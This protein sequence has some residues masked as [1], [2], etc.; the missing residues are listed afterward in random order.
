MQTLLVVGG[1]GFIGRSIC[2]IA[3]REGHDVRSVSRS[4]RPELDAP[5]VDGVSWTSA[6]L[7]RPNAWRDRLDGVDAVVH[8][9]G[10][11]SESATA[12]VT[13]ER[14]NGDAAILTALEAER[15]GVDTFVF[16]SSA[17]KPPGVRNAYI[18]AKRRAETAIADLDVENVT[19]RPGPVYGPEQPHVPAV[20]NT[21]FR[22]VASV[23][24]IA[25][26]LGES[27][28]LHVDRVARAAY[29]AA[30]DPDETLLDVEDVRSLGQ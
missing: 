6:N 27:R 22:V 26:R 12:G 30:L 2:R 9:V 7:F 29:R 10:I 19:L 28:P 16:L 17:V 4:G 21:L 24:P 3:V 23:P 25:G 5:W 8:A 18:T 14:V 13:F 15:A 1:S 11:I 20:V